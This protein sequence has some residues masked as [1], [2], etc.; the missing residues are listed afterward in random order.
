MLEWYRADEPYA[1]LIGD[2]AALLAAAA[3]AAGTKEFA[4]AVAPQILSRSPS[5]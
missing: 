5:G 3:E 1:A 4:I 2:C